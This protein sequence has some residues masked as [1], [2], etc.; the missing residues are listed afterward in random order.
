MTDNR[1][2]V[3]QHMEARQAGQDERVLVGN[4]RVDIVLEGTG[5]GPFRVRKKDWEWV[6]DEPPDRGGDNAGP[7]PLA[8]FLSGAISCLL[9]HYMLCAIE[10]DVKIDALKVTA[11]MRFNRA[12]EVSRIT[13]V[14]YTVS[15]ESPHDR[16]EVA[17]L[18]TRAQ[19]L[20]YAHNTLLAAG[21]AMR[22]SVELNGEHLADL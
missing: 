16:A 5:A 6:V 12:A 10:E 13:H 14:A 1:D 7:N 9:S 22:T 11:R 8:Y 15:L 4:E 2:V 20:C 18:V 21:V 19:E 17:A 3:V